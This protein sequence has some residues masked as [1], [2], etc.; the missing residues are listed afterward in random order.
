MDSGAWWATAHGVAESERT[1]ETELA[2]LQYLC[3]PNDT[4]GW[5]GRQS[6]SSFPQTLS[7]GDSPGGPVV[8]TLLPDAGGVGSIPG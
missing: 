7:S 6:G 2:R 8:K 3:R 4:S 5:L 1:E